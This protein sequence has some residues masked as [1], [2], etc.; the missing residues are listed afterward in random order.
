M[1]A[2]RVSILE[3]NGMLHALPWCL[4]IGM[5][6]RV[7]LDPNLPFFGVLLI[8]SRVV[9]IEEFGIGM[10]IFPEDFCNI[11]LTFPLPC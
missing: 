3:K 7:R 8:P 6:L 10:R 9:S 2:L 5:S 4:V 11:S 1:K